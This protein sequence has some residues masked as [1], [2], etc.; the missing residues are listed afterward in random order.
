[1]I[2]DDEV[3]PTALPP[4]PPQCANAGIDADDQ[5]H[6]VSGSTLDHLVAHSVAFADAVRDVE[7]PPAAA[8]SIAVLRMTTAVVPSTS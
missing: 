7:V 1:M 8:D 6:A 5:S 3:Q 4:R 2:G